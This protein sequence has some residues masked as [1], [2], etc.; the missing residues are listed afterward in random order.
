MF[1]SVNNRFF[2]IYYWHIFLQLIFIKHKIMSKYFFFF[3]FIAFN[4]FGQ[5]SSLDVIYNSNQNSHLLFNNS[6]LEFHKVENKG[7]L[8]TELMLMDFLNLMI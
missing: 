4:V 6:D 7:E 3:I 1:E 8:F 2:S 5:N